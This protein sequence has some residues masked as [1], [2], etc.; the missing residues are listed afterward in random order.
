M[1]SM[2]VAL[3]HLDDQTKPGS[4]SHRLCMLGSGGQF[5]LS[6]LGL[7]QLLTVL[8]TQGAHRVCFSLEFCSFILLAL[9]P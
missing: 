1:R 4:H 3:S 6:V 5:V 2:P 9:K 7:T 8:H